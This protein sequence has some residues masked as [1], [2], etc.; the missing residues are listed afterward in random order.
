MGLF[1]AIDWLNGVTVAHKI[2]IL[3]TWVRLPVRPSLLSCWT[4]ELIFAEYPLSCY[5]DTPSFTDITLLLFLFLWLY[6]S[7][8]I[9]CLGLDAC[10]IG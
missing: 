1:V 4:F 8:C 10:D 9:I 2:L 5:S 6:T 3:V 7:M